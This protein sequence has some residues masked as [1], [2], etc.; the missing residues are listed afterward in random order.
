MNSLS[1]YDIEYMLYCCIVSSFKIY[2][3]SSPLDQSELSR[4]IQD[5]FY[6][7]ARINISQLIKW[8]TSSRL[9]IEYF[10]IIG[11]EAPMSTIVN[12]NLDNDTTDSMYTTL[13]QSLAHTTT[14]KCEYVNSLEYDRTV[15][16]IQS[17]NKRVRYS[18]AEIRSS[19]IEISWVFGIRCIDV[20]NSFVYHIE[21]VGV[22]DAAEA[23]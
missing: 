15:E 21:Y 3:I 11:R 4:F 13:L 14:D 6:D 2:S 12:E 23:I 9:I 10:N 7:D 18:S 22:D 8:C 20:V 5:N 1:V 19:N 16:Y 17:Y